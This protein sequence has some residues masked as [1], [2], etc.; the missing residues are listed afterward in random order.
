MPTLVKRLRNNRAVIFDT[1]RFDDWCV[2]V[3]ESDGSKNAPHDE[4]Y[5]NDLYRLSLKYAQD[6]VYN[7]FVSIY[8]MTASSID[9]SVLQLINTITETYHP[10]DR[11]I[12]EQWFT[13][14]YAGMIAEE[15]KKNA[16][17]KKRIKRLGMHQVLVLKMPPQDAAK[18]S[19]GK[20]WKELDAIMKPL[21]F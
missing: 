16:V 21:G 2:Y 9:A 14:V 10:E 3:V 11:E 7:D 8:E 19:P 15:N 13:V 1:G 6:K 18:F 20:K 5:F 4:T 12:V 17:L